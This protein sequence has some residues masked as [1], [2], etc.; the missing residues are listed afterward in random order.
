MFLLQRHKRRIQRTDRYRNPLRKLPLRIRPEQRRAAVGAELTC[1]T[2]GRFVTL[3]RRCS[4]HDRN[5]RPGR[6]RI[7]REGRSVALLALFAVAMGDGFQLCG[8]VIFNGAAQAA[9]LVKLIHVHRFLDFRRDTVAG[10]LKV[11]R[12]LQRSE[13]GGAQSHRGPAAPTACRKTPKVR[14][15]ASKSGRRSR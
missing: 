10:W 7:R 6:A 12:W 15:Q 11:W 13:S 4:R 3:E 9:A 8:Y 5:R 14:R 1:D 2:F